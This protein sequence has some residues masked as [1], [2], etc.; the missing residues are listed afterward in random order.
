MNMNVVKGF[1]TTEMS[2]WAKQHLKAGA[3]VI[4]DGLACFAAVK[5]AG[6]HHTSIV[7]GGG[8]SCVTREEFTWINTSSRERNNI[9]N[10]ELHHTVF[11][12]S[13]R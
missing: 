8:P 5:T 4:S 13:G 12:T 7:T 1:R 2:R 11:L 3:H 6:C 10:C 9:D